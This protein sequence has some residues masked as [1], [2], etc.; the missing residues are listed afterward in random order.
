MLHFRSRLGERGLRFHINL[1]NLKAFIQDLSGL[2]WRQS[3]RQCLL[4]LVTKDGDGGAIVF[5]GAQGAGKISSIIDGL[6]IG[7]DDHVAGMK[8]GLLGAA[9]FFHGSHQYSLTTFSAEKFTE[10][11]SHVFDH[12]STA[13]PGVHHDHR[14]G[15]IHVWHCRYRWNGWNCRYR[16]DRWNFRHREF[17]ALRSVVVSKFFGAIGELR[18]ECHLLALAADA[19]GNDAANRYFTN[20]T[21]QL[22]NALD[23]R[24][25]H[26]END[27][28]LFEASFAGRS[29]LIYHGH[30]DALLIF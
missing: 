24:A 14:N 6:A 22:L 27:V 4:F 11:R 1:G 29:V 18:F 26:I 3:Q 16:R 2:A 19:K 10:L 9:A 8:S 13:H 28:L 15:I 23:R 20:D 17:K 12:Q 25:V 30:F 5:A 7:F 21:A